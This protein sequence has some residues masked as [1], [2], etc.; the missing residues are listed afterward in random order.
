MARSISQDIIWITPQEIQFMANPFPF[1]RL[2]SRKFW[3]HIDEWRNCSTMISTLSNN[4]SFIY[5]FHVFVCCRFV[6]CGKRVKIHNPIILFT[7]TI[8]LCQ[9]HS[10]EASGML[11]PFWHIDTFWL[12]V[13]WAPRRAAITNF[14]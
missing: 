7:V 1:W 3:K 5:S 13:W 12:I 6:V 10:P 9:S 4:C 14:F 11:N 2:C 8:C